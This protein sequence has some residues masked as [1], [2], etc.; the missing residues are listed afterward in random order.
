MSQVIQKYESGGT[1]KQPS[2]Y[3][4]VND[5][6]D[7]DAWINEATV[8]LRR[9]L[10]RLKAKEREAVQR[11]FSNMVQGIYDGSYTYRPGGGWTNTVGVTNDP[12][13]KGFDALGIAAG[14]LGDSLRNQS[15]YKAQEEKS[16]SKSAKFNGFQDVGTKVWSNLLGPAKKVQYFINLDKLG[17]DK[18]RGHAIRLGSLKTE[19]DKFTQD[20]AWKDMG[21]T[22]EQIQEWRDLYAQNQGIFENEFLDDNEYLALS[23]ILGGVGDLEAAFYTGDRYSATPATEEEK[24]KQAEEEKQEWV[25]ANYPG[26]TSTGT[27]F[28][29]LRLSEADLAKYGDWS[30]N[31]LRNNI[32]K[33]PDSDLFSILNFGLSSNQQLSGLNKIAVRNNAGPIA[34]S[35]QYIMEEI[36]KTLKQRG[37]LDQYADQT[38]NK[39]YIKDSYNKDR[40]TGFVWDMANR[41]VTMEDAQQIPGFQK[42]VDDQYTTYVQAKKNGGVLRKFEPGGAIQRGLLTKNASRNNIYYTGDWA[43]YDNWHAN[44]I[45][46][47]WL[48]NYE[49]ASDAD[50]EAIIKGG[51]DSWNTAGGFDWYNATEEERKH[52][53][54]SAGTQAHQQY[55]IDNLPGLNTEISKQASSYNVPPRA[56]TNDRFVNGAPKGTDND[57][58][59]QT[60]NRRPSIHINTNG[61]DLT[62]WE[63]FY[64]NLGYVGKYQYLDHWVPTKSADTEGIVLFDPANPEQPAVVEPEAA[65][66]EAEPTPAWKKIFGGDAQVNEDYLGDPTVKAPSTF[67]SDLTPDIIGS[68]RLW[69]SLHA[70]KNVYNTVLPS[71]KPVLKNTYERYS[72]ITGAFSARQLKNRQ[73][74]ETLSQ[75]YKPFTSDASLAA[76]RMLEG[77]R[78][79]NQLQTEGFL[80]DDQEIKRTQAEALARQEDNMARRSDVAN[81]NRASINQTNRERAQLKASRIK[82]DWQSWDNFLQ[83]VESRLRLRNEENRARVNDFYDRIEA[84]QAE[85]WYNDVM[86]KANAE[87]IAQGDNFESWD[88]WNRYKQYQADARDMANAMLYSGMSRRYGL[89]Y[90]NIYNQDD[91]NTYK[92]RWGV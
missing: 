71:L 90:N 81:F 67:W 91:Y 19:L 1:P 49:K 45:V 26:R 92:L 84:T 52:G 62:D 14:I 63:D 30:R 3:K 13:P 69:A 83:G 34:F 47:P 73:G 15:V 5:D 44:N 27:T 82:S 48:K 87:L 42:Y 9:V 65:Q 25:K 28:S 61:Q 53:M 33:L 89:G 35:N 10:P 77:Q 41:T 43:G 88:K 51:L 68:G 80:M 59:I 39:F 66:G 86:E 6:I 54:Q 7:R 36:L 20:D 75:S 60:G 18:K 12:K 55:V 4:R 21:A 40:G 76:A 11:E 46:L 38:G 72:P 23:R 22:P 79:A 37:S 8:Q 29:P 2:L 64:K 17:D 16:D 31:T 32:S 74:A 50:W 24:A 85:K 78:H 70:N 58:G 56:N 57:F